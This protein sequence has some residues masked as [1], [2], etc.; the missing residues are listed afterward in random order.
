MNIEQRM[1]PGRPR[2]AGGHVIIGLGVM[3]LGVLI[4]V[5]RNPWI[6]VRFPGNLWPFVLIVLGLLR[7][8]DT[9]A[10]PDGKPQRRGAGFWLLFVGCWGL[11]NEM[12][13]FGLDYGTSWPL[14]IVGAGLL[15]VWRAFDDPRGPATD[16]RREP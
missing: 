2:R 8:T 1:E 9:G 10:R 12:H 6:D 3:A 16:Q 15:I 13:L 11:V 7:L 4:L 14:M 5:D